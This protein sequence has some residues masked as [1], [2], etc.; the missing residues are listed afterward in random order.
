MALP[1][2]THLIKNFN[3]IDLESTYNQCKNLTASMFN[4]AD[5]I[6]SLYKTFFGDTYGVL[7]YEFRKTNVNDIIKTLRKRAWRFVVNKM[8]IKSFI[9]QKK[10]EELESL[11]EHDKLGEFTAE[12]AGKLI[13]DAALNI[14]TLVEDAAK[15]V[16]EFLRPSTKHKTNEFSKGMPPKVIVT[17]IHAYSSSLDNHYSMNYRQEEKLK[18]LD[19]IFHLLDGKGPI[20]YPGDFVTKIKETIKGQTVETVYFSAKF[21]VNGNMHLTFKRMDLANQLAAM[22][23]TNIIHS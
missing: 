5:S 12:A 16:F 15:E 18:D 6:D 7:S 20:K 10:R 11:I 1:N 21:Y 9:S 14:N 4:Q 22:A 8:E 19:N 3:L 2:D 17:W 23:T 13:T